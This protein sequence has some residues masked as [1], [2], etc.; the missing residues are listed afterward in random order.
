MRV[1]SIV[2]M[3]WSSKVFVDTIDTSDTILLLLVLAVP[4]A[5]MLAVILLDKFAHI[6][7]K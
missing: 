6:L 2:V 1:T 3:V 7:D 4:V 5:M